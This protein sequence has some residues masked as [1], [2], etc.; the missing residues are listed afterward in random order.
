MKLLLKNFDY[1]ELILL[2]FGIISYKRKLL[3]L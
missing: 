3:D 2:N 1:L